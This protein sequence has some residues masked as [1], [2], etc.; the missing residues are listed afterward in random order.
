MKPPILRQGVCV[1]VRGGGGGGGGGAGIDYG[2]MK[3]QHMYS[4]EHKCG[5]WGV[6]R[7]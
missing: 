3:V 2:M 6:A 1:C 7:L 4:Q 5:C